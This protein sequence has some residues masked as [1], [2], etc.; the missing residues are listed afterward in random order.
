MVFN[1]AILPGRDKLGALDAEVGLEPA[2]R[3][4]LESTLTAE[5]T[6]GFE[7]LAELRQG[8]RPGEPLP[9]RAAIGRAMESSKATAEAEARAVLDDEEYAAWTK[10]RAPKPRP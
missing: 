10:Q 6:R 2:Q 4:S 9:D 8:P 1:W 3:G 7:A 5:R